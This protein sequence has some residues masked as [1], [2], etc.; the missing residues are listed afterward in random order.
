M[1]APQT[2]AKSLPH[3]PGVYIFK[4][5]SGEIL[6]VGKA[7]D[8]KRRV[9]QYFLR[10]DD[11]E[12][13]TAQLVSQIK[14]IATIK[15]H[16]EFD[17]L[18]LEAK[19]IRQ[20]SPKYNIIA[21]DDKS[22]LYLCITQGA[23]LPRILYVRKTAV[24][25]ERDRVYFGP[26]QSGKTLKK[27]LRELRGIIPYCTAKKRDGRPCFY[28]HLVLCT[29]CPSEIETMNDGP[30][31]RALIRRYRANIRRISDILSGK[32]QSVLHALET[33]MRTRGAKLEFEKAQVLKKSIDRLHQLLAEHYDPALYIQGESFLEN[34]YESEMKELRAVLSPFFPALR[35]LHRIECIDI[36]NTMGSLATGSLVVFID[37]KPSTSDYRRFRIQTKQTPDDVA[38]ITEVLNRRLRHTEWPTADL[39]VIDGGKGQVKS[40]QTV[41]AREGVSL[42]VIGLAK[43]FEEIVVPGDTS[44][45]TL[46][47]PLRHR[48]LQLLERIRDESHRFARS[49]HI[50]L[51]RK[52][53]LPTVV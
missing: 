42:P 2:V 32:S 26:F 15:T 50:L 30:D 47:L 33:E 31:R 29:P 38:M 25:P 36:S 17:A 18:I 20:H 34:V 4:N 51:R 45:T 9:S 10:L 27:V 48:G 40:A 23:E 16:S 5:Q 49:Y 3:V 14:N 46:T 6:Y 19:L 11:T 35:S 1:E 43:R 7:K 41:I 44:F 8:L 52:N 39:L 22:P 21:K 13:K 24:N 37:G 12:S 53:F 28:T